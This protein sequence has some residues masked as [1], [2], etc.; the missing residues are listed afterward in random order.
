M[1]EVA[2]LISQHQ[3]FAGWRFGSIVNQTGLP[4]LYDILFSVPAERNAGEA[5][6]GARSTAGPE[7][8]GDQYAASHAHH[9]ASQ[10]AT[11]GLRFPG[12]EAPNRRA[13][14]MTGIEPT[15]EVVIAS[16]EPCAAHVHPANF[17]FPRI[18]EDVE[19]LTV[20]G[21]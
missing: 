21:T 6:R 15:R 17:H 10:E 9:R 14:T 4:G 8:E 19:R 3:L 18:R 13:R 12:N 1:S 7:A 20:V 11:G 2:R 16:I 5:H